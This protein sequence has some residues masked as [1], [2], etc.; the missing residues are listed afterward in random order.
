MVLPLLGRRLRLYLKK[1]QQNVV[2]GTEAEKMV[3]AGFE[4]VVLRKAIGETAQK[5]ADCI[6]WI[7]SV[8]GDLV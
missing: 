8:W 2:V 7:G 5:L 4:D 6:E 3:I 1:C